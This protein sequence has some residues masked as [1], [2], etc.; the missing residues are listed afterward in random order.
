MFFI[1]RKRRRKCVY[2][3]TKFQTHIAKHWIEPYYPVVP[4]LVGTTNSS[5]MTGFEASGDVAGKMGC[6]VLVIAADT[7][8]I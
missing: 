4:A 8:V 1:L 5:D 6:V 3:L 7:S 2:D